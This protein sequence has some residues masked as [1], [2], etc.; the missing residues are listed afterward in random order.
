[1]EEP[2]PQLIQACLSGDAGAQARFFTQYRDLLHRSAR[3][4]LYKS[5]IRPQAGIDPDDIVNDVFAHLF[6]D[7]C[8]RLAGLRDA[9]RIDA[10]LISIARNRTLDAIRRAARFDKALKEATVA[11]ETSPPSK[12][13]P[14][15]GTGEFDSIIETL[16]P[17]DRAILKLYFNEELTYAE[18]GIALN[19]NVNTVASRAR[20][21]INRLRTK[22][23]DFRP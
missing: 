20:R 1:M 7:D 4:Y 3:L 9:R 15:D 14:A 13:G 23:E 22:A 17:V 16:D 2:L 21:A 11:L 5:G 6:E 18:V 19:M 12:A 10:W 8:R